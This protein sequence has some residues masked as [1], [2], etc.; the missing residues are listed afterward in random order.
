MTVRLYKLPT[1]LLQ[2]TWNRRL[3]SE[4]LAG[5]ASMSR[6]LHP[7][8]ATALW[9]CQLLLLFLSPV[10]LPHVV[11]AQSSAIDLIPI[12]TIQGAG[13]ASPFAEQDVTTW[14]L[15]TGVTG[16]GFYLQDPVGDGDPFTSD[17]LF[18]YTYDTPTV[19]VGQCV[20]V[21]GE[22]VEYF[23]KTEL[24]WLTSLTPSVECGAQGVTPVAL[25][26]VRPGDDP[27][28][29]LEALEGMV[30]QLGV[31]TG[32]VHGPTKRFESGELE[33][34]FLPTQW[35]RY[36]G[37][38]HLFHD[39]VAVS[40]LLFL[41]NRLGAT[42]PDTQ[43]GDQ[44]QVSNGGLTGVLDYNFGKYQLLPWPGQTLTVVANE[45]EPPLL[46]PARADEYGIC[47]FNLHGFG[48][49]TAQFP[50]PADYALAL[51]G[52]AQFIVD[53]LQ[54]CTVIALQETGS[55]ADAHALAN[56]LASDY[57]VA[58]RA[59]SIE[60][61]ASYEAEFPLT[62]SIL[63]DNSRVTVE[64]VDVVVGCAPQEYEIVAPGACP[65]G[66]YPVFDRP[67]LLAKLVIK[68]PAEAPWPRAATVWV[69]DNH[70]K[71]KAGNEGAN[72]RL[73]RR[74]G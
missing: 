24:N 5:A 18:V 49:G 46:P 66:T 3:V 10:L 42:L 33:L 68:G 74:S 2:Q 31:T 32:V 19:T 34:A 9:V 16:D 69:I 41:S 70:W 65:V 44:L 12:S 17:G 43:W 36:F 62:N 8:W 50:N 55:P 13:P 60:G 45:V 52:R 51:Q 23:A 57:G 7:R 27:T 14:G 63:V 20:R 72:V 6:E 40:A 29:L 30:V 21:A 39:Q 37:H 64:L 35:Q 48:Q 71:S 1:L 38:V 28:I 26:V 53:H 47:S 61:P 22:V 67:P 59:L 73:P 54:G 15:V 4:I 58:Y 25:P 11:A 56:T